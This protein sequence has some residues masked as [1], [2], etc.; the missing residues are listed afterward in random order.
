MGYLIGLGVFVVAGILARVL[1]DYFSNRP[2]RLPEYSAEEVVSELN[3]AF[4]EKET[5][6]FQ[7]EETSVRALL[8]RLTESVGTGFSAKQVDT[9][10]HRM[11][12]HRVLEHEFA[13]YPVSAGDF[14][15]EL[16]F[17][18]IR[19]PDGTV[20]V[21]ISAAGPVFE[22]VKSVVEELTAEVEM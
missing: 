1:I 5:I 9:L 14:S 2:D 10:L 4:G 16:D 7:I 22:S 8:N 18:W 19:S 15:C 6:A 13:S 17:Q 20:R 12:T 11:T 3:E 21:G